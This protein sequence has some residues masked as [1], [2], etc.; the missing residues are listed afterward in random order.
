MR[1]KQRGII[2]KVNT[3]IMPGMNDDHIPDIAKKV[4]GLGADIMNCMA[5]VPVKGAAFENVPPPDN[6]TTDARAF[7]V[8]PAFCRR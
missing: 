8:R 2:V 6:L 3:I 5:L 4:S 7:A 1:L